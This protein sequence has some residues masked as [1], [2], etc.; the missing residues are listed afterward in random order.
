M[1]TRDL[2]ADD[3]GDITDDEDWEQNRPETNGSVI[4]N[5]PHIPQ[6]LS[7]IGIRITRRQ[8]QPDEL[9][10]F[11]DTTVPFVILD[12]AGKDLLMFGSAVNPQITANGAAGPSTIGNGIMG[13]LAPVLSNRA[14]IMMG[15]MQD[16]SIGFEFGAGQPAPEALFSDLS[17]LGGYVWNGEDVVPTTDESSYDDSDANKVE[18]FNL[19]ELIHIESDSD[20]DNT[21]VEPSSTPAR[22]TTSRSEDHLNPSLVGAFRHHQ[23]R[24][25]LVN[26]STMS[27]AALSFGTETI[28]GVKDGHLDSLT[29][30]LTPR[31]KPKTKPMAPTSR[32]ADTPT[33]A[34]DGLL[35]HAPQDSNIIDFSKYFGNPTD[36][37]P[38]KRKASPSDNH[39]S[40][41]RSRGN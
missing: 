9:T 33:R 18:Q 38:M 14:N 15:A 40:R 5:E 3:S 31:R 19:G 6:Q 2:I 22:P 26:S 28:K 16:N 21:T 27:Q 39:H 24:Q 29:S 25:R 8:G 23:E 11:H 36:H 12:E 30:S 7:S 34:V 17:R 1:L 4:R 32:D 13:E 10:W 20:D 35:D 41:K 37:E